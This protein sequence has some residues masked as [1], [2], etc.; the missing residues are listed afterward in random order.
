LISPAAPR[1][2]ITSASLPLFDFLSFS[3]LSAFH[4]P[5]PAQRLRYHF[6]PAL[7]AVSISVWEAVVKL[8][9][10][11]FHVMIIAG[12]LHFCP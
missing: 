9:A 7:S 6:T 5:M 11:S 10:H 2:I 12:C 8:E 3:S 4:P 1:A